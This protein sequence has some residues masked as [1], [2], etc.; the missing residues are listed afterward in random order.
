M[1]TTNKR[2]GRALQPRPAGGVG[3]RKLCLQRGARMATFRRVGS[4][5]VTAVPRQRSGG[6]PTILTGVDN[7]IG[8][9]LSDELPAASGGR[10]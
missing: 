5:S 7:V 3:L 10:T 2:H 1:P 6:L 9:T 4:S 8:V